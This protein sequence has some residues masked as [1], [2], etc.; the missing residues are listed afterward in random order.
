MSTVAG[1]L[2]LAL[3]LAVGSERFAPIATVIV[4]GILAST[5]LTLLIIPL[6]AHRLLIRDGA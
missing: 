1:M 2:P 4:G 6:L 5:L 3:E